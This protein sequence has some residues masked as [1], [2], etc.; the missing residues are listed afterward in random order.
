M[1]FDARRGRTWLFG[2]Q[3]TNGSLADLWHW[4]GSTWTA[5]TTPTAPAARHAHAMEYHAAS[6]T[7]VLVGGS[8]ISGYSDTWT[9]TPRPAGMV[10]ALGGGCASSA[11]PPHLSCEPPA[12]GNHQFA[13]ETHDALPVMPG[14]LALSVAARSLAIGPCTLHLA[15]PM[16]LVPQQ[17]NA[18]G[19]AREVLPIPVDPRLRGQNL[20]A[21]AVSLDVN[22]APIGLAFTQGLRLTIGD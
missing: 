14:M 3:S 6:D 21:Q 4:D 1:T 5:V 13:I 19:Y 12:I 16:V 2:G 18:F 22:S 11:T 8:S 15:D 7:V 20:Y 17:L 9:L 10:V